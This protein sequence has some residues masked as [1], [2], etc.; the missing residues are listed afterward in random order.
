MMSTKN[1]GH[2][3]T[4]PSNHMQSE[5]C[6]NNIRQPSNHVGRHSRVHNDHTRKEPDI[7][8]GEEDE[9]TTLLFYLFQFGPVK[10]TCVHDGVTGQLHAAIH[11]IQTFH[12]HELGMTSSC[13]NLA[14]PDYPKSFAYHSILLLS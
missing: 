8:T 1:V 7:A 12:D 10:Y 9:F 2:S 5:Q 3:K 11:V 6:Y 4:I 14:F 13:K